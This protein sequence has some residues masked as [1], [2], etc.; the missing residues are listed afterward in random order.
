[1]DI[2]QNTLLRS[3]KVDTGRTVAIIS[4]VAI[5]FAMAGW[6]PGLTGE[7]A[8]A[9]L[10]TSVAMVAFL[11]AM[12]HIMRRVLFPGLDIQAIARKAMMDPIGAAIVF[13]SICMVISVLILANTVMLR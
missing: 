5:L 11:V 1:M 6:L 8:M 13:A 2:S 12:S 3:L 4:V 10:L 7:P 9:P